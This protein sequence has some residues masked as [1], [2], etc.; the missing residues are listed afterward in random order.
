[1]VLKFT[2]H[3][4]WLHPIEFGD[5]D[6]KEIIKMKR[7]HQD[8]ARSDGIGLLIIETPE[9]Q[10]TNFCSLSANL[11]FS[12]SPSPHSLQEFFIFVCVQV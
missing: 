2:G 7:G 1:M 9:N 4:P 8:G 5:G 11:F 12:L 3:S 10:S 6:A